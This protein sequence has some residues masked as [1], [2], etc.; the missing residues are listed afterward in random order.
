MHYRAISADNH[1]NEPGDIYV[2]RV[3]AVLKERAPRLVPTPDGGEGWLWDGI[4]P[5]EGINSFNGIVFLKGRL[6]RPEDYARFPIKHSDAPAGSYVPRVAIEEMEK[7][8]VD[9]SVWYPGLDSTMYGTRD[10]VLRLALTRAYN[11]WQSEFCSYNPDRLVALAI[12]PTED[13]TPDE[14]IS[15]MKRTLDTGFRGVLVP[16]FPKHRFWD[17]WWDPFWAAAQNADIGVHFHKGVGPRPNTGVFGDRTGPGMW[18]A[19]QVQADLTYT[20]PVAD[21]IFGGVFDRFPRLKIV[22]G[23]GRLAWLIHF[24]Q[25]GDVSY[26]R[27]RFHQK[28][29]LKKLPSEYIRQ[30]LYNTFL[31]DRMGILMREY[32]GVDNQMWS[33]DY[34]HSDS[35]W[36]H[37]QALNRKQF[38]GIPEA[39]VRKMLVI[40]AAKLYRLPSDELD[41]ESR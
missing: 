30:N 33:C 21:L 16:M 13:D 41:R 14:A 25:R 12:L 31:E 10:R 6:W 2:K 24:I 20:M 1:F 35:T 27:H 26:K 4:M 34:P 22:A 29:E 38:E 23:E 9:A 11:D 28:L 36:P 18:C 39:D 19:G 7:D 37:S 15:E 32:I 8:G 5:T 3:P 17:R 40:N